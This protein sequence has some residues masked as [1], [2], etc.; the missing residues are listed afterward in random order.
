[1]PNLPFTCKGCLDRYPGCHDKCEKYKSE[2]AEYDQRRLKARLDKQ[3]WSYV[4]RE[5]ANS[6]DST[7]KHNKG[8]RRYRNYGRRG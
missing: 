1:M 4:N 7:A 2:R 5:I 8:S 3:V 6:R